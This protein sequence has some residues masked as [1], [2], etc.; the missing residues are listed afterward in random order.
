MKDEFEEEIDKNEEE[1]VYEDLSA[2]MEFTLERT[3]VPVTIKD[4]ISGSETEY[5]LRE[6]SG[7]ERDSYM[8]AQKS[9]LIIGSS[10]TVTGVRSF[11]G[12]QAMLLARCLYTASD[13]KLVDSK[14]IQGWKSSV[15]NALFERA[16]KIN[17][18]DKNA[19]K[20]AKN[21]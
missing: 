15:Q 12:L 6:M 11:N 16:N 14:T 5:I 21:A 9:R 10:G 17:G 13:N 7:A 3:E 2:P 19:E 4:P 18:L 1:E 20:R 8:D